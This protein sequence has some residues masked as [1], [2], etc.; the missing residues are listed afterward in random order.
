MR[1]D[2][3]FS[4]SQVCLLYCYCECLN[5]CCRVMALQLVSCMNFCLKFGKCHSCISSEFLSV[6]LFIALYLLT[7]LSL[8]AASGPYASEHSSLSSCILCCHIH[9]P[10]AI[11]E[12]CCPDF[13][14]PTPFQ[15]CGQSEFFAHPFWDDLYDLWWFMDVKF[16]LTERMLFVILST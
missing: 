4:I 1:A 14:I 5:A 6:Y 12:T 8:F 9:F 13:L 16:R 11:P 3:L 15:P 10:A 7:Y 2:T